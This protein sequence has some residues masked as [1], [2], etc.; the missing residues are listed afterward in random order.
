MMRDGDRPERPKPDVSAR[1][2][3]AAKIA[4]VRPIHFAPVLAVIA[5]LGWVFAS[6]I[7]AGPDDDFHLTSVWCATENAYCQPGSEETSRL[8]SEGVVY[9]ACYAQQSEISAACQRGLS[10]DSE[11]LTETSR[12]NFNVSYPPVYY[13]VMSVFV[14]PDVQVSALVMR[15]VNVLLFV[16][17]TTALYLLLPLHRRPVLLWMWLIATMPMGVFL[18][19]SN[20]PSGWAV[21]GVG[22]MWLAVLGY[23]EQQGWRKW[24]LGG[25]GVLTAL[26]AAGSRGDAALYALLGLGAVFLLTYPSER[27]GWRQYAKDAILPGVIALICAY[28]FFTAQQVSAGIG[29]FAGGAAGSLIAQVAAPGL[30]STL[31]TILNNLVNIPFLWAGNFGEWGLGWLDTGVPPV[32]VYAVLAV[33]AV[34]VF[35]GIEGMWTRKLIVVG[36]V[37]LA[38]WIV[39]IWVLFRSGVEVGTAVQPRYL[40]PLI[41]LFLGLALL[42]RGD[43]RIQF[44]RIQ[45]IIVMAALAGANLLDLHSNMRRYILGTDNPTANL[46]AGTEWWW[47]GLPSPMVTWAIAALAYAALIVVLVVH[48]TWKQPNALSA[49]ERA[50]LR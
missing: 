24:T 40:L 35:K 22:S 28:F 20:N 1:Q 43:A 2:G 38:M 6:P 31:W 36:L 13:A 18:I 50:E 17:I 44:T 46:N 5:L 19:A 15:V 12:G 49:A 41:V 9:A 3:I 30:A 23:L 27:S 32:A 25:I 11:V 34:T 16:S 42:K 45:A 26:M 21:V 48:L 29:G 7:G 8:V 39:P 10:F 14:G 4:R 33:I 47:V 37:F